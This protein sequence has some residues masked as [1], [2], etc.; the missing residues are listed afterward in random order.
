MSAGQKKVW[1]GILRAGVTGACVL[2]DSGCQG[3]NQYLLLTT[4]SSLQHEE[5]LFEKQCV[6]T[7]WIIFWSGDVA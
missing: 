4:K 2:S 7:G 6:N 3:P 5:C 1:W